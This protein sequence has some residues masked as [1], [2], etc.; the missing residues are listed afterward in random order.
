MLY[1]RSWIKEDLLQI[2][3]RAQTCRRT[4]SYA[5]IKLQINQVQGK[6]LQGYLKQRLIIK[7]NQIAQFKD[8]LLTHVELRINS[9]DIYEKLFAHQAINLEKKV[10]IKQQTSNT[11]MRFLEQNGKVNFTIM[12]HLFFFV[13]L[14]FSGFILLIKYAFRETAPWQYIHNNLRIKSIIEQI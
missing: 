3:K 2:F 9:D 10:K 14:M 11:S 12:S 6:K 8:E 4:K 13:Q 5:P 1:S 7:M